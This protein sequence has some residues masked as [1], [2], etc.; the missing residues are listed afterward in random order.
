MAGV[1]MPIGAAA[2]EAADASG[3]LAAEAGP[4]TATGTGAGTDEGEA[5]RAATGAADTG[6]ASAVGRVEAVDAGALPAASG[7]LAACAASCVIT[8]ML[9]RRLI[10]AP[11]SFLSNGTESARPT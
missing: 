9:M 6:A 4:A 2:P 11:G 5:G 8:M 10:A 7:D 1:A 3:V